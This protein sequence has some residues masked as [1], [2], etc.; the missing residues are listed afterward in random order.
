ME[1]FEAMVVGTVYRNEENGYSVVTVQVGR[2]E[3]TV[4]GA[5]PV[6][7]THWQSLF[8]NGTGLGLDALAIAARRINRNLKDRVVWRSYEEIM[9]ATP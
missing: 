9:R 7:L 1:T 5:M 6:I 4:V 2:S 8:G 3:T